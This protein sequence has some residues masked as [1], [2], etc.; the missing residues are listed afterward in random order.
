M[1]VWM[2]DP[3][4]PKLT[5]AISNDLWFAGS[6][7]DANGVSVGFFLVIFHITRACIYGSYHY[8]SNTWFSGIIIFIL[9]IVIS[10]IGYILP[11]GQMSYWGAT[12]ITNLLQDIPCLVSWICGGFYISDPTLSRFFIFH[13]ILA[14]VL[15]AVMIFHILYLH[16]ISSTNPL[17]YN[18][19]NKIQFYP[20]IVYKDVFLLLYLVFV[21]LFQV[22]F[23]FILLSHSDNVFEVNILVTPLHIVPEWYFL[24]FYIVLKVIPN[25][26][27]G[28]MVMFL[29]ILVLNIYGESFYISGKIQ[30]QSPIFYE[31][32]YMFLLIL[33]VFIYLL[34]VGAQLPQENYLAYPLYSI[35]LLFLLFFLI[36][37]HKVLG[38][39]YLYFSILLGISGS[40]FSLMLRLELYSSGNRI[41]PQENQNFY[42][43]VFTLHGLIVILFLVIQ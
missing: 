2:N 14:F 39:Y 24:Y 5:M 32:L 42:N 8:I 40:L 11:W 35:I 13:F 7:G 33:F 17:G 4:C 3:C 15:F 38:L 26:N 21:I 36:C 41:I 19:N 10:F 23:G 37:N 9:L 6:C 20:F 29:F 1:I 34:W 25:K 22:Y 30:I 31:V 18:I 43:I 28:F 12:V 16:K 27:T